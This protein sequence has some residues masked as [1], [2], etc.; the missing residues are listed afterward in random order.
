MILTQEQKEKILGIGKTYNLRFAILHGSYAKRSERKNS[1]LDIAVLGY[2]KIK[3]DQFLDL[4]GEFTGLFGDNKNRELDFKTLHGVDSLFRYE[5]TKDGILLY[6]NRTDYEEFKAY[7]Y[8]SY[9]DSRDLRN[10][11]LTLLKK[12]IRALAA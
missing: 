11:E 2:E 8:R 5:V 4:Y 7:A 6:G 12:S 1:D 10:L 9:I 3:F